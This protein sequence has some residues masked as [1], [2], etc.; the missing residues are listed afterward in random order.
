MDDCNREVTTENYQRAVSF[1]KA[2][3]FFC[4]PG[5]PALEKSQNLAEFHRLHPPYSMG[6]SPFLVCP[7]ALLAQTCYYALPSREKNNTC[8]WISSYKS[9]EMLKQMYGIRKVNRSFLR[10]GSCSQG[11]IT[12]YK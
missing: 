9:S 10:R 11:R 12:I 2:N 4:S 5:S 6:A 1:Q 7:I 8:P 3:C